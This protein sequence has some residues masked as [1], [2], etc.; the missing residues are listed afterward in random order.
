MSN[1]KT[2]T[3]G[4]KTPTSSILFILVVFLSYLS[5]WSSTVYSRYANAELYATMQVKFDEVTTIEP[6]LIGQILLVIMFGLIF[7]IIVADLKSIL[8]HKS[9]IVYFAMLLCCPYLL[10]KS[11]DPLN[12]ISSISNGSIQLGP[13]TLVGVALFFYAYKPRNWDAFR[14]AIK[15]LTIIILITAFYG[16]FKYFTFY[17]EA[18]IVNR[19]VAL[20]WLWAPAICLQFLLVFWISRANEEKRRI[21]SSLVFLLVTFQ[22][23]LAILTEMRLIL[24]MTTVSI[25]IFFYKT[26]KIKKGKLLFTLVGGSTMVFV[27]FIISNEG[28][29]LPETNV[30]YNAI[31]NFLLRFLADTRSSDLIEFFDFISSNSFLSFSLGLGYSR[32]SE[33]TVDSGVLNTFFMTGVVMFT[34][35]VVLLILPVIKLGKFRMDSEDAAVWSVAVIWILRFFTSSTMAF[36]T[37]FLLFIIFAGR[38]AWILDNNLRILKERNR[39]SNQ[40]VN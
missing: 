35:A 20:K 32:M 39:S 25:V 12:Y 8:Q 23:L 10:L 7:M 40:G 19:V 26:G 28:I 24:L 27:L 14:R 15:P 17:Q 38:C 33:F 6:V 11:D 4:Y 16:L 2:A 9:V 29:L 37:E 30:F 36:T 22:Y 21:Y 31:N 18:G 34:M 5:L 1:K 13:W 3:F